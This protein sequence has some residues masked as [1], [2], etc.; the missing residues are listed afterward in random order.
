MSGRLRLRL[1][2]RRC[3]QSELIKEVDHIPLVERIG[4]HSNPLTPSQYWL[5][6][7]SHIL[8]QPTRMKATIT[9]RVFIPF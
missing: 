4:T 9:W 3:I 7:V 5:S 8:N 1:R 6:A 2:D